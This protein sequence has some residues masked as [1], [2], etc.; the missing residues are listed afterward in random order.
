MRR[1]KRETATGRSPF[2]LWVEFLRNM[3]MTPS[4]LKLRMPHSPPLVLGFV[5]TL[6]LLGCSA[7]NVKKYYPTARDALAARTSGTGWVPIWLPQDAVEIHEI[8]NLDTNES[9]LVA[10]LPSQ[11]WHP[12]PDCR[13]ANGGQFLVPKFSPGWLPTPLNGYTFFSCNGSTPESGPQGG[14]PLIHATAISPDGA[15]LVFWRNL[16]K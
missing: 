5:V 14:P 10:A 16:S 6:L 1:E 3:L 8:H 13:P 11:E 9:A 15:T 12:P 4:M 2:F 7:E